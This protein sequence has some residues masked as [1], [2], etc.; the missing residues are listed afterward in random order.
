M[1][2]PKTKG[3]KV[4]G[5][6]DS[7]WGAGREREKQHSAKREAVL[8]SAARLFTLKGFQGTSLD[9]IAQSLGVTKPTL[10]Y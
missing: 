10:Y 4:T 2:A 9:D 3:R 1:R 6:V 7:P 8:M 5:L